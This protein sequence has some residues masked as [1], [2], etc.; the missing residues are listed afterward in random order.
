MDEWLAFSKWLLFLALI[1]K[2]LDTACPTDNAS[3]TPPSPPSGPMTRSRAKAIHDKVNSLLYM[4]DLDPTLDGTLP[5]ANA[6]C[7][8]RYD[9]QARLHGP[10]EDGQEDGQALGVEGKL[11]G[12]N[13]PPTD[14]T[15]DW[16]G[17]NRLP[18]DSPTDAATGRQPSDPVATD[19]TTDI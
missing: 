4:C 9:P 10:M 11:P 5:H 6:L 18:T 13:R 2:H 17:S 16:P 15:T 14:S 7:I 1:N 19:S 8:L 12:V 3:S